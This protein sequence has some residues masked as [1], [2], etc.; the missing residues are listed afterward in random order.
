MNRI[1]GQDPP[2]ILNELRQ[3]NDEFERYFGALSPEQLAATGPHS[4]GPRSGAWFV[5]MR[6]AEVA[7]HRLDLAR[8][9]DREADLDAATARHLL[10]TLLEM[11]M[12]AVV[13]RDK[14]G[15]D[16][17]Y[18]LAVR[19]EPGAV[20]RLAFSPGALDVTPGSADADTTFE[21]DPAGLALLVYARV[22]WPELEQAGRLTVSGSRE[23]AERF[24]TLFKGP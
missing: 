14:T 21:T 5:D 6:L 8:S 12:P 7:F 13:R 4:H 3:T 18:A 24:H 22:T 9:L 10:P 16:G 15:G 1:A 20:W 17:T 23:A 2:A 19:G 11:N